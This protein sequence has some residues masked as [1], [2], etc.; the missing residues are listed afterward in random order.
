MFKQSDNLV[1]LGRR[2]LAKASTTTLFVLNTCKDIGE[3]FFS[4]GRSLHWLHFRLSPVYHR[5]IKLYKG[6]IWRIS[7]HFT[8][9]EDSSH[10]VWQNV[11][12]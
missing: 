1:L 6:N 8:A 4:R 11:K 9:V 10:V 3:S 2:T 12:V 5:R 7:H